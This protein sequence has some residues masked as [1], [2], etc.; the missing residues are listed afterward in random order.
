MRHRG[1]GRCTAGR[2]ELAAEGGPRPV[3]R[4]ADRHRVY[5]AARQQSPQLAVP[6]PPGGRPRR[7]HPVRAVAAAV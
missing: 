6:D 1:R 2:A 5:R 3:R 4:T 7:V